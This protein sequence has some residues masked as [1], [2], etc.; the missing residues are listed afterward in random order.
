MHARLLPSLRDFRVHDDGY[1]QSDRA[2]RDYGRDDHDY[3]R[4]D[5][6]HVSYRYS[7]QFFRILSSGCECIFYRL[8]E[9]VHFLLYCHVDD[10]AYGRAFDRV[11]RHDYVC[12]LLS[13]YVNN[14]CDHSSISVFLHPWKIFF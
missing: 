2:H 4:E 9:H 12:A 14:F 6:L 8:H 11:S 5:H 7:L 3:A 10:R 13:G 1:V